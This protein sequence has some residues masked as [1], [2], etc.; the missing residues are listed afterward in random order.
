MQP[1]QGN[2]TPL[3]LLSIY[4]Y[5][6][7]ATII[8]YHIISYRVV[9]YVNRLHLNPYYSDLSSTK[10]HTQLGQIAYGFRQLRA[11]GTAAA[12]T[13]PVLALSPA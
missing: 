12:G 3:P 10:T 13:P 5:S 7:G 9:L 4:A 11:S 1:P 6:K 2:E 8:P